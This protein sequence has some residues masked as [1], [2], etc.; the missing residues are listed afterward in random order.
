MNFSGLGEILGGAEAASGG[1]IS[2][3]VR[4]FPKRAVATR[5]RRGAATR[6]RGTIYDQRGF[7]IPDPVGL[8]SGGLCRQCA[9]RRLTR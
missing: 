6:Q 4:R 5:I 7:E 9:E 8:E 3:P 1:R 2:Q